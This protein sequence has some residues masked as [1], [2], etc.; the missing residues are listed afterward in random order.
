MGEQSFR[1]N[2]AAARQSQVFGSSYIVD[3][4]IGIGSDST[5][6]RCHLK[7]EPGCI[8]ALKVLHTSLMKDQQL[9]E[10]FRN[11]VRAA[12]T[13]R[14]PN[15]IRAYDLIHA[16]D[17]VGYTMEFA[18]GGDLRTLLQ[19][20]GPFAAH[21]VESIGL[22]LCC[23][24]DAIH[25]SGIV[26]RDLRLENIFLAGD[27]TVKIADFAIAAAPAGTRLTAHGDV[28]GALDYV[29]PEYVE[30]GEFDFRSDV[31]ALGIVLFELL[32]GT[33]PFPREKTP[34]ESLMRRISGEPLSPREFG[35]DCPLELEQIIHRALQADPRQRFSSVEDVGVALEGLQ[36]SR[37]A[38][39][40][41][42]ATCED[43]R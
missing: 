25:R 33:Y 31:Y 12:F 17:T 5:V 21:Q 18:A 42:S 13:V 10:R 8:L 39:R 23:G 22:Q 40:Q 6:Y 43:L 35:A 34:I 36:M 41:D 14:H 9:I 4:C 27:G 30:R 7:D 2:G 26:H 11:E 37:P 32:T 38:P 3:E 1:T 19:S 20:H 16:D 29:S 24:L 28:I 15:V